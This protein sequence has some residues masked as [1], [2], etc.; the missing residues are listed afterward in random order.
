[1]KPELQRQSEGELAADE[2][3]RTGTNAEGP[4]DQALASRLVDAQQH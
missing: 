3:G 1:M 4:G 2:R